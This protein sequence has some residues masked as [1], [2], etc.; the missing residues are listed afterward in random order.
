MRSS[1]VLFGSA[2][3]ILAIPAALAA[4]P[5]ADGTYSGTITTTGGTRSFC[6]GTGPL[7]GTVKGMAVEIQIKANDGTPGPAKGTLDSKGAFVATKM[8][9]SNGALVLTGTVKAG[10]MD[11]TW[12]G[13]SCTGT[14]TLKKG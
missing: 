2:F 10:T 6:K 13:P 11:G 9:Q 4:T 5:K 8:L 14:F 1:A 3:A 12:K 7:T